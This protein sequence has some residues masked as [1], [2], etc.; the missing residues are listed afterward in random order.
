M[1]AS[2]YDVIATLA[3]PEVGGTVHTCR[4]EFI[5]TFRRRQRDVANNPALELAVERACSY[6]IY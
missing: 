2:R 1:A 5:P 4:L 6:Y 3:S